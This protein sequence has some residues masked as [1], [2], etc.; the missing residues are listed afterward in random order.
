MNDWVIRTDIAREF[1]VITPNRCSVIWANRLDEYG[2]VITSDTRFKKDQK[3]Q[4][5]TAFD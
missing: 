2:L 5:S 1:V 3:V 4:P